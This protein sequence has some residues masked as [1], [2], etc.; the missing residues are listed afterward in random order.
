MLP[1]DCVFS[2]NDSA[3]LFLHKQFFTESSDLLFYLQAS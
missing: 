3:Q 2:E 1:V